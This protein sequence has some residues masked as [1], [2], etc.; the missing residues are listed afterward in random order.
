MHKAVHTP[1]KDTGVE[2]VLVTNF[3]LTLRLF[4][5]R[6]CK[7]RLSGKLPRV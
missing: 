5:N 1:G 2:E 7:Y 6:K 4:A 3:W